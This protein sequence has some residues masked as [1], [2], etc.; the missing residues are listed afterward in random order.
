MNHIPAFD[1][2]TEDP[3]ELPYDSS[4]IWFV[5]T[6]IIDS[7]KMNEEP[8][9]KELSRNEEQN[10][11]ELPIRPINFIPKREHEE[12]RH[13]G[14]PNI[15]DIGLPPNVELSVK[16]QA[17]WHRLHNLKENNRSKEKI[18]P[19]ISN[20]EAVPAADIGL[21]H[22]KEESVKKQAKLQRLHDVEE[23]KRFMEKQE[24]I[25]SNAEAVNAA[26]NERKEGA[27]FLRQK[28]PILSYSSDFLVN[29]ARSNPEDQGM[30]FLP[31]PVQVSVLLLLCGLIASILVSAKAGRKKNR[32]YNHRLGGSKV[33]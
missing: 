1:P 7:S 20:A 28:I 22:D 12:Y 23:N 11:Q 8:K 4:S 33:V 16:K 32:N 17:K 5:G 10:K 29:H 30:W 26:R 14:L 31:Y 24:P 27:V 18:E 13:R 2:A 9:R 25:M 21:S 19:I 6:K 3:L 15:A